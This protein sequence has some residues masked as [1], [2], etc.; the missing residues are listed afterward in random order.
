MKKQLL[1]VILMFGSFIT[2]KAQSVTYDFENLTVGNLVNQ[3][4]WYTLANNG[5]ETTTSTNMGNAT[6]QV[7]NNGGENGNALQV[8]GPDGNEG[9]GIL[10]RF[11]DE[12]WEARTNG[13]DILEVDFAYY[14]G[15]PGASRNIIEI[16][17]F[18]SDVETILAGMQINT[19]TSELRGLA[20]YT[21]DGGTGNYYFQL[22]T[23]AQPAY[24]LPQN[25]WIN[26]SFSYNYTTGEVS[27]SRPGLSGS[28]N[29]AAPETIPYE[30]SVYVTAGSTDTV[31]NT[32]PATG[33]FDNIT[34]TATGALGT[35][36]VFSS[37]FSIFPNPASNIINIANADN[38]LVNSVTITDL[39]GRVVKSVKYSAATEA[40]I[41]ISDLAPGMYMMTVASD[42]GTM[43][44][45]IMKN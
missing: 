22:G 29:G 13:N 1:L 23:Q 9:Q 25:T 15:M 42:K 37:K 11:T 12:W 32:A 45:K 26:L 31:E 4:S 36:E 39:N 27:F 44:K 43:T 34:L 10:W 40:Q 33:L 20:W 30:I 28:V 14:A 8:T 6:F 38:I 5:G 2:V 24:I 18:A 21:G 17:L 7:V 3:D 35:T 41:N 19:I 16:V